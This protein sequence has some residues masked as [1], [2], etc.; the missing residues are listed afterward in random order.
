MTYAFRKIGCSLFLTVSLVAIFNCVARAGDKP[1][2]W[3]EVRTPHFTVVSNGNEKQA[4]RV[5][6]QFEQ[7][8]AVMH[9][10]LPNLRVDPGQS[11]IILAVKNENSLKALLPG[12]W[13]VK[14]HFHPAGVFVAGQEKHYVA[15]RTDT[16][17]E[18]PYHVIYH[19]YIHAVL[20]L[21]FR[22]LP[23]WL[24][25]GMAEFYGNS[26]IGDKE[27]GLGRPDEVHLQ[28]LNENKLLPIE[29]LLQVDPSSPYYNEENR[30][31]IFYAESWALVHFLYTE[32]E[33]LQKKSLNTF[34][35][36]WRATGDS[37]KAA[38]Q[39]FGDLKQ[40]DKQIGDYVRQTRFRYLRL[41]TPANL[42]EKEVQARVLSTAE[43]LALRGDFLMHTDR[44][45][46]A[47]ALLNE[48]LRA[49]GELA[50]VHES[51]GFLLYRQNQREEAAREF[52]RAV[53]LDSKS[54]RAHYYHAF[55]MLQN[56]MRPETFEDA[57]KS[58]ERVIQLNPNFAPAYAALSSLYAIHDERLEDALAAARKAAELEPGEPGYYRNAGLILLR[59]GRIAEAHKVAEGVL[60]AARTPQ[61]R[62]AAEIFLDQVERFQVVQKQRTEEDAEERAA[63][64]QIQ[65]YLKKESK[66]E[67]GDDAAGTAASPP[68]APDAKQPPRTEGR[69]YSMLGQIEELTCSKQA[70]DLTLAMS[71]IRMRLHSDDVTK[72][73]F[74]SATWKP[75]ANFNP[76]IHLKGLTAEIS[77]HLMQG[78]SYD[79]TISTIEMR[80]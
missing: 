41:K 19:E 61:E 51:M 25:E 18:N 66:P 45:V 67:D 40:F 1:E 55:L 39:A 62:V 80:R 71:G 29:A 3:T 69:L 65:E 21:N 30:A 12:F 50:Q 9:V 2:T 14:G 16:E 17:G 74:Q 43:S 4:R 53:A 42:S 78:K 27:V 59:M 11:I 32:P 38:Q 72:I 79:G 70:M 20:S 10:A 63:H 77:Y 37:T 24:E 75:P 5:A 56:S 34:V 73:R 28:L 36:A 6:E 44:P 13:E 57:Q 52:E 26:I 47:R 15:L 46:E 64:E 23:L 7:I 68:A 31:S 48:A 22:N 35:N 60:A 58:L 49:N 8:R 33:P 76:C 54:T